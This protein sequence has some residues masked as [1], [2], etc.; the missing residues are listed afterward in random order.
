MSKNLKVLFCVDLGDQL[1]K[2]DALHEKG[3]LTDQ[4]FET[5]K[6]RLLKPGESK[7]AP[8]GGGEFFDRSLWA[9][10]RYLDDEIPQLFHLP[11]PQVSRLLVGQNDYPPPLFWGP[12]RARLAPK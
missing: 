12:K 5:A 7:W 6:M 1:T 3:S 4:E 11:P 10:E 2:I 8:F 9:G